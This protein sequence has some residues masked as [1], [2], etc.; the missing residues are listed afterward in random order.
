M[1]HEKME[2]AGAARVVV[3]L[4]HPSFAKKKPPTA[5]LLIQRISQIRVRHLIGVIAPTMVQQA[6]DQLSGFLQSFYRNLAF[7]AHFFIAMEHYIRRNLV[8]RQTQ[9]VYS[10]RI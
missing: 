2:V 4:I 7:K 10:G 8:N 6:D 1:K 3:K 5:A 9:V